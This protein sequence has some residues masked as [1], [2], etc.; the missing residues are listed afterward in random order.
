M[1]LTWIALAAL[2]LTPPL[3]AQAPGQEPATQRQ[4]QQLSWLVGRWRGSGTASPAFFE[5]YR[6]RDDSTIA[7]T[8]YA[9]STFAAETADSSVIELRNG[10]IQTRTARST[11]EVIAFAPEQ[12]RFRRVGATDGGHQFSRVSAT[13]WSATLY[14][15]GAGRDTVVFRMQR[16][17]EARP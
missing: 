3:L 7:M 6:F 11:Y 5:Q 15:R 13:E 4:F 2:G 10:R 9:D 14:P 1:N 16:V 12:V 17:G 8:A